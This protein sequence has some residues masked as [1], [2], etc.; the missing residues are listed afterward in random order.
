[1][2]CFFKKIPPFLCVYDK[3]NTSMFLQYPNLD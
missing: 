2:D 1:M 3:E